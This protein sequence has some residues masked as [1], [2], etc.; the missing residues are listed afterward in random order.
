MAGR[1]SFQVRNLAL[2]KMGV[3]VTQD[4]DVTQATTYECCDLDVGKSL[5]QTLTDCGSA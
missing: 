4:T 2:S 1:G 5:A 3:L